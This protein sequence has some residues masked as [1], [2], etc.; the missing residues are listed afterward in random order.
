MLDCQ[1]CFLTKLSELQYL[2]Y[3][4]NSRQIIESKS[5]IYFTC[6]YKLP[7]WTT[8]GGFLVIAAVGSSFTIECAPSNNNLN[9]WQGYENLWNIC[10][11]SYL[12]R[13]TKGLFQF[14]YDDFKAYRIGISLSTYRMASS[15][16]PVAMKY[17]QQYIKH[18]NICW[19]T[20]LKILFGN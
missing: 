7:D 9:S 17:S 13:A 16:Q 19:N 15:L 3:E 4:M 6:R 12:N 5:S 2:M 10:L 20:F 8:K 1:G 14:R 18:A 11:T